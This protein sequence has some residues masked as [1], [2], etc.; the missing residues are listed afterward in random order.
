MLQVFFML[1][2]IGCVASFF[3]QNQ[4]SSS[5]KFTKKLSLFAQL[6]RVTMYKKDT[7]PYCKKAKELLEEKYG[8]KVT[9]VDVEEPNE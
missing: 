7:C 5:L 3:V 4:V 8:L 2:L 9:Y 6:G 1:I